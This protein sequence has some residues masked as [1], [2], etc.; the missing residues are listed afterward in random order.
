MKNY[1][2]KQILKDLYKYIEG[3]IIRGNMSQKEKDQAKKQVKNEIGWREWMINEVEDIDAPKEQELKKIDEMID[4]EIDETIKNLSVRYFVINEIED[5]L[6]TRE[7]ADTIAEAIRIAEG[8]ERLLTNF[9]KKNRRIAIARSTLSPV[10]DV[11][12]INDYDIIIQI[13]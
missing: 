2:Q 9:E 8:T 3:G 6:E 13:L 12:E 4:A 5:A 1:T 10:F 11:Y 7:E